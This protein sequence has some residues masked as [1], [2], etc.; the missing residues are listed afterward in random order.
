MTVT[1]TDIQAAAKRIDGYVRRTP[2]LRTEGLRQPFTDAEL[3][4]KLEQLQVTGSFKARGASS[5]LTSLDDAAVKRGLI[6]A[7]GGNHGLGVAYAGWRADVPTV[8]Y[9]PANTPPVKAEK[10]REW[11]ATVEMHGEVWDD[12][13]AEALQVAERDGLTYVHPFADPAV[14]AGQGTIALELA[15]DLEKL[16]TLLVAIGG[17]G[18]MAGV[19]TGIKALRP[20]VKVIGVEPVGAPTL[21]QSL[22]AGRPVMLEA[23]ET[24]ANTLAPRQSEKL[25]V[26]LISA[27]VEQIVLVDDDA[28]RD[29]ARW[30]WSECAVAAELSGAASVA[31][32]MTGAYEAQKGETVC[33]LVC[34]AG[35]DG[36]SG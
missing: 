33:A 24:R 15:A 4:L 29:A 3:V 18:L 17:G 36:I 23:I 20:D 21:Y 34:G 35:T 11:G 9:L 5:K 12:A 28:M 8:I 25:N 19:A 30:L 2:I 26:D 7:S 14:I 13:N 27:A 1:L 31:A 16:D 32:L 6:T 10:L 22:L